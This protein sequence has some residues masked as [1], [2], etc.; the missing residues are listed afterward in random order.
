MNQFGRLDY[1][2]RS[3][4]EDFLMRIGRKSKITM[5]AIISLICLFISLH[6]FMVLIFPNAQ[7]W[8]GS[9][10]SISAG[11]MSVELYVPTTAPK[12]ANKRALMISLHGCLQTNIVLR[13]HGNWSAT[14]DEYGM[15]VALPLV[16]DGG[17]IAGCWD[18]FG[19]SAPFLPPLPP[20][21]RNSRDNDNLLALVETLQSDESFNIDPAQTYITGLSSG[22]GQTLV[23]GCLAP[24]IFA[25][26]GINAAPTIGTGS[27]EINPP[28]TSSLPITMNQAKAICQ[29]LAGNHAPAFATQITSVIYDST[30]PTVDPR[31]NLLNAEFITSIYKTSETSGFSVGDLPG[32]NPSGTGKLWSDN[33]GPRFSLIRSDGL[34]HAWPA[35]SGPGGV[36]NFVAREGVNYPAYVTRFFFENNRRMEKNPLPTISAAAEVEEL[37]A[38]INGMAEDDGEIADITI[39]IVGLIKNFSEGPANIDL[40]ADGQFTYI[41]GPLLNDNAYRAV[42]TAI[43][44]Q[45][46][47]SEAVV[48]FDIGNPPHPPVIGQITIA[49]DQD[50]VAIHGIASDADGDL[51]RVEVSINDSE[52]HPAIINNEAWALGDI[53]GLEAGAYWFVVKAT[54]ALGHESEPVTQRFSIS[55]PY[56]ELNDTLIGHVR[57]L[58]IRFYPGIG[59]GVADSTYVDLLMKH[60]VFQSFPLYGFENTWYADTLKMLHNV[61]EDIR[62]RTMLIKELVPIIQHEEVTATAVAGRFDL[63]PA[64]ADNLV[65]SNM[66]Q[67]TVDQ[68]L[69]MLSRENLTI[70]PV[71]DVEE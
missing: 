3:I 16:P 7:S 54:D 30:D 60:G 11:G 49:V 66:E 5:K 33:T 42:V 52:P 12:L 21:T 29:D 28:D 63:S 57:N 40:S 62:I 47:S 6:I 70:S 9:W 34:G 39:T 35:G 26:M 20:H 50:C 38:K 56:Q 17:K 67:F 51:D 8:A 64:Q 46:A 55:P 15:I 58:R 10:K 43:D 13:D 65:E 2:K 24:E 37:Q 61:F 69:R 45:G 36:I 32:H 19:R 41:S 44:D 71:V 18:Y 68:L 23:M 22:G 1:R 4:L 25:G 48:L 59:Y 14:A 27:H 31:Y 53:C